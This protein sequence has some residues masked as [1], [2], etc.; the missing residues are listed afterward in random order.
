[1][2]THLKKN[3]KAEKVKFLKNLFLGKATISEAPI[4]R[5]LADEEVWLTSHN[6]EY[7]NR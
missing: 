6:N 1:M 7:Q 3:A 5:S 2:A 4:S